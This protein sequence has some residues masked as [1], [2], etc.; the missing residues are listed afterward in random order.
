MYTSKINPR[1]IKRL[2]GNKL[3]IL[4]EMVR[5]HIWLR[6]D[7]LTSECKRSRERKILVL[8]DLTSKNQKFL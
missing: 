8:T 4:K 2:Y 6:T 1:W 5:K 3:Q 7:I